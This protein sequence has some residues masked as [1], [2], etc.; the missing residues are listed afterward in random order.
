MRAGIAVGTEA[1]RIEILEGLLG[2]E[3]HGQGRHLDGR[4]SR[5]EGLGAR[6]TEG[7]EAARPVAAAPRTTAAAP[8]ATLTQRLDLASC[9]CERDAPG[10]PKARAARLNRSFTLAISVSGSKGLAR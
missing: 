6:G 1:R 5:A 8:T 10:R 3:A 7:T 9:R 4:R 2:N